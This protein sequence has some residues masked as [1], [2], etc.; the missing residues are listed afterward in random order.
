M[1]LSELMH[2][3]SS[4]V[5][6]ETELD[7]FWKRLIFM[8]VCLY[9]CVCVSYVCMWMCQSLEEDSWSSGTGVTCLVSCPAW[10]LGT[11][12]WFSGRTAN[13][14]S[15]WAI[16]PAPKHPHTCPI[17]KQWSHGL[18]PSLLILHPELLAPH[19]N[20]A[21]RC[22]RFLILYYFTNVGVLPAYMFV[23]YMCTVSTEARRWCQSP[24]NWSYK[25]LWTPTACGC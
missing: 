20:S 3:D 18:Y 25:C 13:T 24:W 8:F 10:M 11:N 14:L 12:L 1:V 23:H 21:T 22:H 9:V 5:L 6:S 15:L 2:D 7:F 19:P 17:L 4:T 16:W